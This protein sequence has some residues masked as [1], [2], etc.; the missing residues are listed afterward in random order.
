MAEE[1]RQLAVQKAAK[2]A[3]KDSRRIEREVSDT[4]TD[5]LY[6][7][8]ASCN[9]YIIKARKSVKNLAFP[10][11]ILLDQFSTFNG[12]SQFRSVAGS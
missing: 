8:P 6:L 10:G 9:M 12:I 5:I 7:L 1:D 4:Y 3:E 11:A 2:K